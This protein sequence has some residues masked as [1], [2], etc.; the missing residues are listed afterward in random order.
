MKASIIAIGD[1]LLIGQVLDTNSKWLA[2]QLTSL[3][4]KV[5][6]ISIIADQA[7]S[8]TSELSKQ[9][10]ESDLVIFTGGLGPTKDDVTKEALADFFEVEYKLD[11]Q[12]LERMSNWFEKKGMG[13]I[14]ENRQQ[15]YVPSNCTVLQNTL[16]TAPGM[17][18]DYMKKSIVSLP[19][20]PYEMKQL[21]IDEV[22][23]KLLKQK[24]ADNAITHQTLV[25]SGIA[26]S[27][28]S[29]QLDNFEQELPRGIQLSYL[30]NFQNLR[31]RL[32]NY[33][34]REHDLN[35]AYNQLKKEVQDY[36]IAEGDKQI[37]E[38][39]GELLLEQKATVSFA[40][41]CSGGNIAH[42]MTS[43][44]GSSRYFEGGMVAYSYSVKENQ[45]G[46]DPKLLLDHGA[47]SQEIVELMATSVREK[48]NTDYAL[49]VSGIAG[50][51]GGQPNKPVGTV[52]ISVC[53]REQVMS[54]V[55]HFTGDRQK[56]IQHT[57]SKALEYLRA[58]ITKRMEMTEI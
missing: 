18:F 37:E 42:L 34:P 8:I 6:A 30:P 56:V 11:S 20:V 44:P 19:G 58:L 22:T 55:F 48:M 26:E 12:S 2:S 49:A 33:K 40:E 57:T 27:M 54:K 29:K 5:Q 21:F 28:L 31:L 13:M 38:I 24:G 39:V 7:S 51:G 36:L 4:I 47:V 32:T 35:E 17:W 52:W 45:L 10:N 23:P 14:E 3:G 50:P 43:V 15:A 1:E 41:S 53:N 16:G 25:V 9:L 46:I